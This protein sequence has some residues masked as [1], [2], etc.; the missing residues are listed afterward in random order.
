MLQNG[1]TAD[2][3]HRFW[4][5]AGKLAHSRAS[6]RSKDHRLLNS[7]RHK[8]KSLDPR[9]YRCSISDLGVT[10]SS[11]RSIASLSLS[12]PVAKQQRTNPSPGAPNAVPGT[13]ATFCDFSSCIENSALES[14]VPLMS[15]KA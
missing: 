3:D 15:G 14:P 9:R 7:I 2:D 12:N 13:T 6:P 4:Q 1:F 8:R 5:V 10:N 11:I